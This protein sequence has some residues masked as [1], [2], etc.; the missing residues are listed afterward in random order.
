MLE[1]IILNLKITSYIKYVAACVQK[2]E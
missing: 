1:R 2:P